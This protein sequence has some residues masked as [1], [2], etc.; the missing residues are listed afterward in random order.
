[1]QRDE[2]IYQQKLAQ[3]RQ[4][5]LVVTGHTYIEQYRI[6]EE[7]YNSRPRKVEWAQWLENRLAFIRRIAL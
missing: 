1:M 7:R 6:W 3:D 2:I 4:R 5:F